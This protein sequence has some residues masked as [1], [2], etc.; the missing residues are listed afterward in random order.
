MADPVAQY[1]IGGL[2]SVGIFYLIIF[3]VGI[4]S[5]WKQKKKKVVN[6]SENIILAGRDIGLFIGVLTMTGESCILF[7]SWQPLP[8][9]FISFLFFSNSKKKKKKNRKLFTHIYVSTS[10]TSQF[11]NCLFPTALPIGI[12]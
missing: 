10:S 3:G 5:G 1:N 11:H 7:S 9:T 12:V 2:I 4:W 8:L 6:D